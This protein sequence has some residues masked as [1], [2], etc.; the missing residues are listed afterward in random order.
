MPWGD[1]QPWGTQSQS[2]SCQPLVTGQTTSYHSGDDGDLEEG[3]ARDYTVNTTG[4]QAGTSDITVNGKTVTLSNNTV[5]DNARNREWQRYVAQ[6]DIGPSNDGKLLWEDATN[7]EDIFAFKDAAN[8]VNFGGHN[9]W[10]VPNMFELEDLRKIDV[11]GPTIDTTLFPS[12]PAFYFWTSS[13]RVSSSFA[14]YVDFNLAR[15]NYETKTTKQYYIRLV[16]TP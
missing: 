4:D 14:Y 13:S 2:Q 12:T 1:L 5:T 9:D 6:S 10:R 15:V 16:R 11:L 3:E 8:A 7:G